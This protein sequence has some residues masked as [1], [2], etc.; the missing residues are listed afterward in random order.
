[1]LTNEL[2]LLLSKRLRPIAQLAYQ[3]YLKSAEYSAKLGVRDKPA[4][5][6]QWED[7]MDVITSYGLKMMITGEKM[8]DELVDVAN[9]HGFPAEPVAIFQVINTAYVG[10]YCRLIDAARKVRMFDPDKVEATLE[11]IYGSAG[12]KLNN[13]LIAHKMVI[14]DSDA[15]EYQ[16]SSMVVDFQKALT[17]VETTTD[18]EYLKH[19]D[20]TSQAV[21]KELNQAIGMILVLEK[22]PDGLKPSQYTQLVRTKKSAK[23]VAELLEAIEARRKELG[24]N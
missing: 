14:N 24:A 21:L 1:M 11:E 8:I 20:V 9:K 4:T 10:A 3:D 2:E 17:D 13:A 6:E 7:L 15:K 5:P 18:L 23:L 16:E 12:K 22:L 19:L